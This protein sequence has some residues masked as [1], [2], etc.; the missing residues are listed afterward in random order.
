MK[1]DHV[2][3]YVSDME[4]ALKLYRDFLGF[5]P[6]WDQ[7]FPNEKLS[8]EVVEACFRMRGATLRDVFCISP[9]GQKLELVQPINPRPNLMSRDKIGYPNTGFQELALEVKNIDDW[10]KKV[11]DA[12]YE[13]HA[14]FVWEIQGVLRSFLFYDG[15]GNTIQFVE[16]T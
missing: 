14:D 13:T 16:N 15:E 10:F 3:V 2:A 1:Y 11:K 8:A 9:E 4:R 12:G 6:I 7:V 5:T